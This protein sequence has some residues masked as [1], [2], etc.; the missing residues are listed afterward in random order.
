LKDNPLRDDSALVMLKTIEGRWVYAELRRRRQWSQL[1][2]AK[3]AWIW[4]VRCY[5]AGAW[6]IHIFM[7]D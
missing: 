7:G 2:A 1:D 5:A 3:D 4:A 6:K